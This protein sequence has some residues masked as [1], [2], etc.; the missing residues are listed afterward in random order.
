MHRYTL[1]HISMY[2]YMHTVTFRGKSEN[3]GVVEHARNDN[4]WG[5]E[6]GRQK[7]KA[8]LSYTE[9]SGKPGLYNMP[10][11]KTNKTKYI[12]TNQNLNQSNKNRTLF[13][14]SH[15]HLIVKFLVFRV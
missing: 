9:H 13:L 14:V 2:T 11:E 6:S 3:L 15:S 4:V 5:E 12:H 10:P 1:S 7:F 8:M